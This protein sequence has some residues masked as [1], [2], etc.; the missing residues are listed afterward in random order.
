MA[1]EICSPEETSSLGSPLDWISG[2][3]STHLHSG[4][5]EEQDLGDEREGG[6]REREL[7]KTAPRED[8]TEVGQRNKENVNLGILFSSLVEITRIER[9]ERSLGPSDMKKVNI[10]IWSMQ[11]D[12]NMLIQKYPYNR[13][14]FEWLCDL[15]H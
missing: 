12:T 2:R 4:K 11:T 6:G 1:P 8:C 5:K 9:I 7:L 14:L 15:K 10:K 3:Q 13:F